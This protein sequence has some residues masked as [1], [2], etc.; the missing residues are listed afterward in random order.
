[1]SHQSSMTNYIN[2]LIQGLIDGGV[3]QAVISPG[4]R[5]TPVSIL[6]HQCSEI[7]TYIDVDERSA[8]FFAL[9]LSKAYQE[10]VALVCTSGTAAANYLPAISEA[11]QSNLPLVV[12]TT[13]RPHELRNS[14][15]PQTMNQ[16]NLYGAQVKLFVELALAEDSK[17][18][19]QYAYTQ[20]VKSTTLSQVLPMGPV[21]LNIPLR[22]P[23]LP[24]NLLPRPTVKQV[25]TFIG[26]TELSSE[27]IDTLSDEWSNKKGVF[28]VGPSFNQ[29]AINLLIDVSEK[30]GWPIL[31][32]PLANI[33]TF[34]RRSE[35]ISPYYDTYLR[36]MKK[37]ITP[38]VIVRFGKSPVSKPLN[39]WLSS[40]TG[41]YYLVE[42]QTEWLDSSKMMTTLIA[43]DVVSLLFQL[44]SKELVATDKQW[45]ERFKTLDALVLETMTKQD[46]TFLSEAM[47]IQTVYQTMTENEQLFVSNSMPIRDL[48]TYLPVTDTRFSIY[49]NRGVNGIDGVT[50]TALGLAARN[51]EMNTRLLIGDLACFHDT[52]GLA[53]A[54]KYQLPVTVILVNNDGGGI[55]SMLSQKE[56]PKDLF[57]DLFATSTG[58]TFEHVAH[59]Y[60][61]EY[62][63]INAI[64][65]L[66]DELSKKSTKPR[67]IEVF[68]NREENADMRRQFQEQVKK[69][70]E[71][72]FLC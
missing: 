72:D 3:K 51:K 26:K 1:M 60:D 33:R 68:T 58:V 19:Y 29:E 5:S 31:A 61:I 27:I 47:I 55:F 42:S 69:A 24:D 30:L 70:I 44:L 52:T 35:T 48:D 22:E 21:H 9:G 14:G 17:E 64:N 40:F 10:P 46:E 65:Q 34:G 57:D 56:L 49:G 67:F 41:A 15:A 20:G 66:Q 71:R 62:V 36:Y 11:N 23:L 18:M 53:M 4:S 37:E 43:S 50:S 2:A 38:D 32:D 25:N 13:D 59:M 7:T 12:L 6:L 28:V 45:L 63:S 8:G 54:K 39:Q 16:L